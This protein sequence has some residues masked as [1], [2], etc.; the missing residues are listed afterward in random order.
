M[1]YVA[2]YDEA[3]KSD[4]VKR[5]LGGE[6]KRH[7]A[8]EIGCEEHTL[9]KWVR[10][11]KKKH[12]SPI[13]PPSGVTIPPSNCYN[14]P[15][16]TLQTPV[17]RI[18]VIPDVQA[19]PGTDF[20]FLNYIGRYIASK[21]PQYVVCIGDFADLPSLSFH[22]LPGSKNFEGQRYRA[23]I[24]AVHEAMKTLMT[25]MKEEMTRGWNPQ[26][27]LTLGNH[28]DRIN[29]TINATPKLDGVMG[30]PDLEYERWGWKIIPFLE[31]V[32]IEGIAFCHYFCSGIMGRAI[33]SARALLTKKHMSCFAGHQQGRDIA[34]GIRGDGKEMTAII[35]GSAYEHDETY[36]NHQTNNHFRGLYMLNDVVDGTFEECPTSLKYLRRKYD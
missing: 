6:Y 29:R 10:D 25:P 22:D 32:I 30:L 36:L 27:V 2:P 26:L 33:T 5:A 14:H 24:L 31:P 34:Y 9:A 21:R 28:E 16:Q 8:E 13:Q 1:Q 4:A 7:V 23:D 19:K 17:I 3:L 12:L 18:A 20:T 35:C 15:H 11:Y